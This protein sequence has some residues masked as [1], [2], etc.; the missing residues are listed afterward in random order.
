MG[1][2]EITIN[3]TSIIYFCFRA[4]GFIAKIEMRYQ[5][6]TDASVHFL[7]ENSKNLDHL[8]VLDLQSCNIEGNNFTGFVRAFKSLKCLIL[9]GNRLLSRAGVELGNSISG[10][11]VNFNNDPNL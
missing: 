6:L 2:Q 3:H 11:K 9:S 8:Q 4:L 5:T 10:S 7:L 1:S